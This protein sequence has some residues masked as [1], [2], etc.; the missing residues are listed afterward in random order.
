LLAWITLKLR[1]N[2]LSSL[3]M[4]VVFYAAGI[5]LGGFFGVL[6]GCMAARKMNQWL[7][8]T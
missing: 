7:R 5:G 1:G 6:G 3:L 2:T 8:W 4:L